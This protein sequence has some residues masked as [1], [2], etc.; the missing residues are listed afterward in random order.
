MRIAGRKSCRN[1][2]V[3]LKH[4][5]GWPRFAWPA[6][7]VFLSPFLFSQPTWAEDDGP[8]A[9]GVFLSMPSD[10]FESAEYGLTED[11]KDDLL[12]DGVSESWRITGETPE[13]MVFH[14][15]PYGERSIGIQLFRDNEAGGAVAVAGSLRDP[16]CSLEIWK[17]DAS[18]KMLP[19]DPPPEPDIREFFSRKRVFK[20]SRQTVL[21]CLEN[22]VLAARPF[23]WNMGKMIPIKT[24]RKIVYKW[25][26]KD[27]KK[28]ASPV[29]P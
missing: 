23:I 29:N 6:L 26:G 8:T 25:S 18:G 27:F 11:E 5:L 16:Y 21:L 17:I 28:V 19:G 14:S 15:R 3:F 4:E 2:M 9:R 10:I 22:G 12:N 13:R 20:N 1:F 24:D 7:L